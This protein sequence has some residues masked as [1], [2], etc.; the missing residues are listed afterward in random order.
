MKIKLDAHGAVS[1]LAISGPLAASELGVLKAG[2]AK[3]LAEGKSPL[4]IDLTQAEIPPESRARIVELHS[5][6]AKEDSIFVIASADPAVAAG[7]SV[8][9]CLKILS[10][11]AAK[12]L[13]QEARL[14]SRLA[15]A[16]AQKADV[17]KKL[18]DTDALGAEIKKLRRENGELKAVADHLEEDIQ[19]R[20]K[21][22]KPP[23][24]SDA[25]EGGLGDVPR[26]HRQGLFSLG[27]PESE[28]RMSTVSDAKER[29]TALEGE[30]QTVENEVVS[31]KG[32][33]AGRKESVAYALRTE[34]AASKQRL[35]LLTQIAYSLSM[36]SLQPTDE[37]S[38]RLQLE[39]IKQ[40]V[41]EFCTKS[42]ID[43]GLW[44]NLA[45]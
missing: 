42:N 31:L 9:D 19:L 3:L 12:L 7:P 24:T 30:L 36:D 44:K 10:S 33:M 17:L 4:I 23:F 21:V 27:P 18:G 11:P 22:R 34:N 37:G 26:G 5:V 2:I 6:P 14:K 39:R 45:S 20:L 32:K 38:A 25:I 29:V 43:Q 16:Q 41:V 15:T 8:E 40:A 1:V 28:G 35:E 13:A